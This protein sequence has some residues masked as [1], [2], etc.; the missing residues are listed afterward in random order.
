MLKD[1]GLGA[2]PWLPSLP[3]TRFFLCDLE[4]LP[5]F[6]VPQFSHLQNRKVT[7]SATQGCYR[8]LKD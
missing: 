6:S 7:P 3:L 2:G 5:N 4:E 1:P 8:E